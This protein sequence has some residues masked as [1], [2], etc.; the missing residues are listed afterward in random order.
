L[1][2]F[3]GDLYPDSEKKE[4]GEEPDWVRTERKQFDEVR[5][6]NKDGKMDKV[7]YLKFL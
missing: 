1:L 6:K 3:Q 4:G 5:D 7:N 2:C